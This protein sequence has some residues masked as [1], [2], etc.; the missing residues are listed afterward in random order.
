MPRAAI[1]TEVALRRRST[2]EI[3]KVQPNIKE[4]DVF[5]QRGL[6]GCAVNKRGLGAADTSVDAPGAAWVRVCPIV[7]VDA[8]FYFHGRLNDVCA[9][10]PP[11]FSLFFFFFFPRLMLMI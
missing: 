6:R 7:F 2:C 8:T 11:V 1:L 4:A 3:G 9:V 5:W 10:L